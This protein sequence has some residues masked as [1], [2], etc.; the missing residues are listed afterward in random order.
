[1]KLRTLLTIV[2]LAVGLPWSA[3]AFT[4]EEFGCPVAEGCFELIYSCDPYTFMGRIADSIMAK[5]P[6]ERPAR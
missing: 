5:C 1:M 6:A 2:V 4:R 3:G